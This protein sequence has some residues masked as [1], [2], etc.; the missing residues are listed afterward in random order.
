MSVETAGDAS[1]GFHVRNAKLNALFADFLMSEFALDL[2][3]YIIGDLEAIGFLSSPKLAMGL[4]PSWISN[5][6]EM[7]HM[8][9][10]RS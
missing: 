1:V 3:N 4:S 7:H 9:K 2:S 6:F 10:R 8:Q 5:N